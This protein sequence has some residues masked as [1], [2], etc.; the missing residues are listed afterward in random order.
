MFCPDLEKPRVFSVTCS[1]VIHNYNGGLEIQKQFST[2][3]NVMARGSWVSL[4]LASVDTQNWVVQKG[5]DEAM[6]SRFIVVQLGCF[7][8]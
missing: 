5:G 6:N 1:A 4:N 7:I 3:L 8:S 2:V